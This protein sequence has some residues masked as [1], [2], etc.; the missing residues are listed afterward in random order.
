MNNVTKSKA[1]VT[2]EKIEKEFK[3]TS[4]YNR[5]IALRDKYVDI[6][7]T[8]KAIEDLEKELAILYCELENMVK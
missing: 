7:I 3:Y 8:L 6:E 1:Q 5:A 4:E 2:L